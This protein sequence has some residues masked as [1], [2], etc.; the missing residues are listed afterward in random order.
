MKTWQLQEAKA[1]F[2]EVVKNAVA[3]G[4]QNITVRGES[5]VIV[6]SIAE[7]EKLCTPK[8]SLTEFMRG[9]PLAGVK[10]NLK[11]NKSSTRDIDL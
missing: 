5:V 6:L 11:R 7:F 3:D 4:P 10:L 8:P 2:S 9:S 1:R